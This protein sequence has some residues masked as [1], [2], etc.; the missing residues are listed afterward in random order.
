M[1]GASRTKPLIC[2]IRGLCLTLEIELALA[3]AMGTHA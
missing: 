3:A 2:A 1:Q